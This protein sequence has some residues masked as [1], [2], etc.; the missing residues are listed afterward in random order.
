MKRLFYIAILLTLLCCGKHPGEVRLRGS[1]AHLEQGEFYIYGT[2]GIQGAID[3]LRIREG[4]FEYTAKLED[5]A[6]LHILY[7]NYSTLTVFAHN[8]D[9]IDIKGD[10]RSLNAVKVS[11]NE[12]NE[13]YTSFR[14]DVEECSAKERP[15]TARR[16]ILEHPRTLLAK[17]LFAEHMLCNDSTAHK[18]VTEVYD[19]LL[20]ACPEDAWLSRMAPKVKTHGTLRIGDSLPA[21]RLAVRPSM[22]R[23][24]ASPDTVD[25]KDMKDDWLLISFW[26]AWRSGSQ[27]ALFRT[28]KA[29]REMKKQGKTLQ[30][31]GYSLDVSEKTLRRIEK[32]DSVDFHSYCDY[33]C[34]DS[35]LVKRWGVN[36]LPFFILVS[37]GMKIEALG[38]DWQKDIEPKYRELC[39]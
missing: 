24:N 33:K 6:V 12:D 34:F 29:I 10:A 38:S 8:G 35:E 31:I 27:S 2:L 32:V 19:S 4:K 21:F 14:K 22:F 25:S 30:A 37:P 15:A 39:L 28:R 16:Y 5:R 13:L 11:G 18:E 36:Q 26:A 7:P 17:Y 1:F 9:N 3:T 20:R 23:E